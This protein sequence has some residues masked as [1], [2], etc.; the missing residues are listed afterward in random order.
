MSNMNEGVVAVGL[1]VLAE[2]VVGWVMLAEH[3]GQTSVT[4]LPLQLAPR[5]EFGAACC[6]VHLVDWQ[7]AL[8]TD[9][10]EK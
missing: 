7:P 9:T 5:D 8:R 10:L 1:L 4:T 3:H 6:R 2:V